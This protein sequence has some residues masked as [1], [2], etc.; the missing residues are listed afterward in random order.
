M[1]VLIIIASIATILTFVTQLF[2]IKINP[3]NV[4]KFIAIRGQA[5]AWSAYVIIATLFTIYF[6]FV[7]SI[8]IY[9]VSFSIGL[10]TL[11]LLLLWGLLG[12]WTPAIQRLRN[13]RINNAVN[14]VVFCLLTLTIIGFWIFQWPEIQQPIFATLLLLAIVIIYIV[15]RVVKKRK[16]SRN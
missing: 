7:L 12:I 11:I 15:D 10:V 6:L 4:K 8:V 16:L 9:Y 3:N 14:F 5:I 1:T 2:G 13:K